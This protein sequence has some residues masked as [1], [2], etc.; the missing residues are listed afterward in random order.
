DGVD[1]AR[2]GDA[3]VDNVAGIVHDIGVVAGKAAHRVGAA[4]A[5]EKIGAAVAGERVGDGTSG[6]ADVGR[7]DEDHVLDRAAGVHG[8]GGTE[9]DRREDGIEAVGSGDALINDVAGIV[10]MVGVIA[11]AATHDVSTR[12]AVKGVVAAAAV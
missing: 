5:V 11:G 6:D 7:S 2:P 4:G 12:P 9:T 8:I 3:L 10:D 1:P